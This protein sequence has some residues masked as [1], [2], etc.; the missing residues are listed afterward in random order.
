MYGKI[1]SNQEVTLA[2]GAVAYSITFA[3]VLPESALGT[4][5]GS[6]P[7]AALTAALQAFTPWVAIPLEPASLSINILPITITATE[8]GIIS[9]GK[10]GIEKGTFA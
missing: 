2:S 1:S 9:A 4:E 5:G 7:A 8:A 10:M 3:A 6:A